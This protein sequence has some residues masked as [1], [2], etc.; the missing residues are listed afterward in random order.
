MVAGVGSLEGAGA[1]DLDE[2]WGDSLEC[3]PE[4]WSDDSGCGIKVDASGEGVDTSE[5]YVLL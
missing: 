3:D 5:K 2:E 1:G 4:E